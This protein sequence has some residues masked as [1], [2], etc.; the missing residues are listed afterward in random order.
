MIPLE[1]IYLSQSAGQDIYFDM[2]IEGNRGYIN[3][4]IH[5]KAIDEI[6]LLVPTNYSIQEAYI[7][8]R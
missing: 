7:Y 6:H 1:V 2:M 4:S 3:L 8:A 5:N